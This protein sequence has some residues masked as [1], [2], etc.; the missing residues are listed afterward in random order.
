MGLIADLDVV[1][2]KQSLAPVENGGP[3]HRWCPLKGQNFIFMF[4]RS[5][6]LNLRWD[7]SYH[8]LKMFVVI[9][10]PFKQ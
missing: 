3:T 4:G 5:L 10:S 2:N 7:T 1:Y 8:V 6:S 9:L